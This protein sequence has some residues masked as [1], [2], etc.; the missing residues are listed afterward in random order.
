MTLKIINNHIVFQPPFADIENALLDT[1]DTVLRGA[2][3]IPRFEYALDPDEDEKP[4]CLKP[5]ILKEIIDKAKQNVRN[6]V[7]EQMKGNN[8]IRKIRE[9]IYRHKYQ[10]ENCL[11]N[12]GSPKLAY[13]FGHQKT[14]IHERRT[15]EIHFKSFMFYN[16]L[17][18]IFF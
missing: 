7:R 15:S 13:N 11:Y 16:A 9:I 6:V 18:E 2:S 17:R 14:K 12:F 4:V 1:Y 3:E 10:M 5:T 8:N